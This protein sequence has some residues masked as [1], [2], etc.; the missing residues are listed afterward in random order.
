M[1]KV[2]FV[3]LVAVVAWCAGSAP[4]AAQ[5]TNTAT[6]E[7]NVTAHVDAMAKLTVDS[8]TLD[9]PN[10][11]PDTTPVV[12]APNPINITAKARTSSGGNVTLTVIADGDLTN[13]S[14]TIGIAAIKWTSTG[15]GFVAGTMD[16][17]TA[18][19]VCSWNNSST[20][21][22]FVGTQRYTMVNSWAYVTGTY[23]AK[24]T[25]TLVAP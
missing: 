22:G 9:F 17:G 15:A 8:A 14:D 20:D 24:L 2:L 18:Q 4:A 1:K 12:G 25:Y 7:V 13:G 16:S 21:A 19:S 11:D 5:V 10:T 23:T 6:A 3:M